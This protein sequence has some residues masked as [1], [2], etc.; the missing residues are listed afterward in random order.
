MRNRRLAV[1]GAALVLLVFIVVLVVSTCSGGSDPRGQG[2]SRGDSGAQQLDVAPGEVAAAGD[3]EV[4]VTALAPVDEPV[5]PDEVVDPGD[6][7]APGDNQSF[8][9]AFVQIKNGGEAPVRIDPRDFWLADGDK[10]VAVDGTRSGPPARSLLHGASINSILTFRAR[11]GLAPQLVYRPGWFDGSVVV[12]GT[13]LPA[14]M[15]SAGSERGSD[16]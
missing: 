1:V 15:S 2:A 13:L 6:P 12:K 5:L 11:A 4:V 9:Q 14:G 7:P 3:V 16:Q 10:L 8:Y